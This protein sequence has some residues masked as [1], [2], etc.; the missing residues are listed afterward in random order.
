MTLR[1]LQYIVAVAETGSFSRAAETVHVSQPTLS[2]Q[3]KKLET[4]LGI[5]IFE[6]ATR[7]V[8]PTEAGRATIAS[9][10]RILAEA[11]TLRDTARAARDPLSGRFR[12]GAIPTLAG[13]L[14]PD[15]VPAAS[16]ALPDLKL[17]LVE[18]KTDE[19]VKRLR[20]GRL[21]AALLA[22]PLPEP[23]LETLELFDDDFL[24]ATHADDPLA[25]QGEM[26]A[27]EL[28]GR[29]LLLLE[30]GHCLRDQSLEVCRI[31]GAGEEADFRAT[32]L[33]TLRQMV[34]AGSGQT[35]MPAIA[36]RD[37]DGVAYV[38]F[39][40]KGL[41]RRVALAFRP[42]SARREVITRLASI[43]RR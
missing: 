17:V 32:S 39:S 15:L 30:D 21:D 29:S 10:R 33:E 34:R 7:K 1:E 18:E 9:A 35:L 28:R 24:F 3:V 36:R 42:T 13:Y 31:A 43:L 11:E 22:L 40:G 41:S 8:I 23:G 19:L 4:E 2:A 12:L 6:R 25:S 27:K 14:L 20:S 5:T 38:P 16:Q 26:A 37:G